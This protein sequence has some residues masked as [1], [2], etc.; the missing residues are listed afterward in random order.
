MVTSINTFQRN[1]KSVNP[2]A[3]RWVW[4][5]VISLCVIGGVA[6]FGRIVL[7]GSPPR[8]GPADMVYINAL[9]AKEKAL[10]LAHVITALLFVTL[11]PFYF[12]IGLRESG[13]ELHRRIGWAVIGVGGVLG[14][15]ALMM[16]IRIPISANASAATS[17][18]G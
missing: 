17:L 10:T 5:A 3:R 7:L 18:Y 11:V 16:S 14:V 13:S 6:V 12:M 2:R 15:T 8:G 4:V 9:F 1:S